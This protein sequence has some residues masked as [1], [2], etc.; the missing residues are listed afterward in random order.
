MT[1]HDAFEDLARYYDP[2]MSQVN[3]DRWLTVCTALAGLLPHAPIN[4]LDIGCGTSV[5]MKKLVRLGWNTIGMDLS[6]AMLH[7]GRKSGPLPIVARADMRA[8]PVADGA[9]DY[10]TSLFDSVNFLLDPADLWPTFREVDRVLVPHG[11]YYFDVITAR[12]VTEHFE[13]R[14]WTEKNGRFS[15]TWEGAFDRK[16]SVAETAIQVNRNFISVVRERVH[17]IEEIRLA[18]TEAG[19]TLLGAFDAET[20]KPPTR[21]TLRIDLIAAKD[22]SPGTRR[23]FKAIE[24]DLRTRME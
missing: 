9:V 1:H 2:I 13:G 6:I 23:A 7:A 10:V 4:H 22:P 12:M 15:T 20:W 5:L 14:K 8:L 11:V 16:T 21:R 18:L 17:S 3:Y 24:D 19:L